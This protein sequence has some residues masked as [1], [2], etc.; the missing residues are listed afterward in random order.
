MR[1]MMM[2]IIATGRLMLKSERNMAV[3]RVAP[4]TAAAAEPALAAGWPI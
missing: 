1:P 2:T 3:Y 4:A